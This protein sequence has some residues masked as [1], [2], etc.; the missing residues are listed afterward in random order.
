MTGFSPAAMCPVLTK[1]HFVA[2]RVE[3]YAMLGA[4]LYVMIS[5]SWAESVR[6]PILQLA[7]LFVL[8]QVCGVIVE[9]IHLPPLLG[10]LVAGIFLK[11]INYFHAEGTFLKFTATIRYCENNY[12]ALRK[13]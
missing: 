8:A 9:F 10:M 13:A 5:F 1:L 7:G 4:L 6:D 12:A 11:Y 3:I 2:T